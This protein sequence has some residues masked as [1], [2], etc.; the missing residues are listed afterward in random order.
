[1]SRILRGSPPDMPVR[2]DGTVLEDFVAAGI[3]IAEGRVPKV[4]IDWPL[5]P[6]AQKHVGGEEFAAAVQ[7]GRLMPARDRGI[8]LSRAIDGTNQ[9]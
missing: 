4:P 9:A 5:V 2:F 6:W 7:R 8:Y 1:M 3:L